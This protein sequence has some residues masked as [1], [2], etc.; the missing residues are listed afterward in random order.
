MPHDFVALDDAQL[1]RTTG[2]ARPP[3]G[4]APAPTAEAGGTEAA[5]GTG[6]IDIAGLLS[7]AFDMASKAGA[8][9]KELGMAQQAL[10]GILPMLKQFGIG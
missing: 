8:P 5:A 9:P 10:S 3:A 1:A 4:N 6:G 7:S 2:G